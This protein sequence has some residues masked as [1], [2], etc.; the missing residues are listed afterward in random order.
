MAGIFDPLKRL[1]EV[2]RLFYLHRDLQV[3]TVK[4]TTMEEGESTSTE[5]IPAGNPDDL[6]KNP[7][8]LKG[9]MKLEL[10]VLKFIVVGSMLQLETSNYPDYSNAILSKE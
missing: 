1:F 6:T 4:M 5:E 8:A 9:K 7:T 10:V 3:N 2:E